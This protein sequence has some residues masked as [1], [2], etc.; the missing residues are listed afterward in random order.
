LNKRANE[1]DWE[2]AFLR[3]NV[4]LERLEFAEKALRVSHELDVFDSESYFR[5][6]L[7]ESVYRAHKGSFKIV[8]S[9]DRAEMFLATILYILFGEPEFDPALVDL[10][11]LERRIRTVLKKRFPKDS[12]FSKHALEYLAT[13][14][15]DRKRKTYWID[16]GPYFY[17]ILGGEIFYY[18]T[19]RALIE[20]S[21][22]A[23]ADKKFSFRG[24]VT[25]QQG[26][27]LYTIAEALKEETA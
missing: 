4:T 25:W 22:N 23:L 15:G 7:M 11:Q 26:I 20:I 24:P 14:T 16:I 1:K 27:A 9:K 5:E 21:K 6:A 18:C 2:L 3:K 12:Y 10:D 13:K 8:S 19:L 17:T